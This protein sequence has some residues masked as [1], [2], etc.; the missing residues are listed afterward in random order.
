ML[1]TMHVKALQLT[2]AEDTVAKLT[3]HNNESDTDQSNS[4][5]RQKSPNSTKVFCV[6]QPLV[7]LQ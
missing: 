6:G 4:A 5:S 3:Y 1:L 7:Y 2:G